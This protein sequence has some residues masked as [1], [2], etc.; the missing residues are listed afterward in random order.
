[1][2]TT[3]PRAADHATQPPPSSVATRQPNM[4]RSRA[5]AS[6][7]LRNLLRPHPRHQGV[8]K[9]NV[10]LLRLLFTLMFLFLGIDA[11][12][13]ILTSDG[14]WDPDEAA[15]WSMWAGFS[16]LAGL[17]IINP[18]KMLPLVLLEIVYKLIWLILVAYPLWKADQ[19]GGSPAEEMTY[20]FLW[21]LLP[22][23]AVP[24]GYAVRTYAVRLRTQKAT[25]VDQ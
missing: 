18:V 14:T 22:I 1:M 8:R 16:L 5:L 2:N 7:L 13:R 24:W 19:L 10:Y 6:A 4:R 23:I 17:G 20:N 21:V 9:I 3:D 15:A 25:A 12:T 11:W